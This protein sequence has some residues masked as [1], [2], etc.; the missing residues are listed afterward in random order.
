[1]TRY[2]EA[3]RQARHT[4]KSGY[5]PTPSKGYRPTPY[6][7]AEETASAF[8]PEY[9]PYIPDRL[10]PYGDSYIDLRNRPYDYW[11]KKHA[12]P[13]I[14]KYGPGYL[15]GLWQIRAR[16]AL[17]QKTY[18]NFQY[19]SRSK[20]NGPNFSNKRKCRCV[21]GNAHSPR[22]RFTNYRQTFRR[23]RPRRF[24]RFQNW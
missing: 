19:K 10:K 9:R 3:P 5:V 4:G 6:G 16:Q 2:V 24:K 13:F 1:M 15:G 8:Y 23:Q 17:S 11:Y 7:L 18:K 14:N 12:K 21:C 22:R 20:Y